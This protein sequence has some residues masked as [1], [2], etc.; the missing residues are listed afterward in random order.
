MLAGMIKIQSLRRLRKAV[1][2]Q[3]PNP[4]RAIG[5]DQY[6]GGLAQPVPQALGKKLFAQGGHS[7]ARHHRAAAQEDRTARLGLSPLAQ[8][9]AGAP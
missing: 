2:H 8:A 1:R 5:D 4:Q 6:F 3:I 9:K 7:A